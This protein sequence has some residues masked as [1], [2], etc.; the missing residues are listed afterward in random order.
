MRYREDGC[1]QC[2]DW[3]RSEPL[4][5]PETVE[6]MLSSGFPEAEFELV[7]FDNPLRTYA[8]SGKLSAEEMTPIRIDQQQ[9]W[10]DNSVLRGQT[11]II[12]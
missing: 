10:E 3:G 6:A 12:E 9:S 8:Q 5:V 4:K 11:P 7:L 2:P 1:Q